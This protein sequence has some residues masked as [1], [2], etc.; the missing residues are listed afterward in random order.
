M[1]VLPRS[2][3]IHRSS[4]SAIVCERLIYVD[5][6]SQERPSKM[7]TSL[8][9]YDIPSTL[10]SKTWSPNISKVRLVPF[11]RV[12]LCNTR[13]SML[14]PDTCSTIKAF[15][16]TPNGSSFPTSKHSTKGSA[17][18]PVLPSLTA[19]HPTTHSHF[20]TITPRAPLFPTRQPSPATLDRTYPETP[21]VIPKGTDAFHYAFNEALQSH[22]RATALWRITLAKSNSILNPVSE[23]YYR[24]TREAS[25]RLGGQKLEDVV[26][27]GEEREREW[28]KLEEVFGKSM[29]GMGRGIGM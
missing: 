23:E 19:S 4:E 15:H 2:I 28:A 14:H 29:R 21:S 1:C 26:L 20:S 12:L 8:T 27:K 6:S 13:D 18:K 10:P 9:L 25:L 16:T 7:T 24:R 5:P 11:P 22:F 17:P 3:L